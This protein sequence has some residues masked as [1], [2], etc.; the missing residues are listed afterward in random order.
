MLAVRRHLVRLSANPKDEEILSVIDT[1][2]GALANG[3]YERAYRVTEH[4]AYYRWTPRL[5]E[6]VVRGYGLKLGDESSAHRVSRGAATSGGPP[7]RSID[8]QNVPPGVIAFVEHDLPL[9]GV[10]SDLTA[11]FRVEPRGTDAVLI[12]E[13][14]HVL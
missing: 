8:R 5:I 12:L 3:D 9:D 14:I 11:T 1:W 4:D 7:R 10:W 13:D 2:L 6:E